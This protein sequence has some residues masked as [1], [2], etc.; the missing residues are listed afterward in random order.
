MVL[1]STNPRKKKHHNPTGKKNKIIAFIQF[2]LL[3]FQMIAHLG[4]GILIA[5]PLSEHPDPAI[6]SQPLI[7]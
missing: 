1:K 4:L 5:A 2:L 3:Q 6:K 7:K